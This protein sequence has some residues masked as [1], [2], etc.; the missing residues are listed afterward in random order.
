MN[1]YTK[2]ISEWL[3]IPMRTALSVQNEMACMGVDFSESTGAHLQVMAWQ[4]YKEM[5]HN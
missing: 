3:N 5:R 2:W 1:I 4:V